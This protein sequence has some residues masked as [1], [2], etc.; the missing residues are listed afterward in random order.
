MIRS[1][2]QPGVEQLWPNR[3]NCLLIPLF[4]LLY[5]ASHKVKCNG[6]RLHY[7]WKRGQSFEDHRCATW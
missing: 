1:P 6:E 2:V 7:L 3:S 4:T 5:I